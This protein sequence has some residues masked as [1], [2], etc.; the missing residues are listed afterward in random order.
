MVVR[1]RAGGRGPEVLRCG[2]QQLA[3]TYLY[4]GDLGR[5][6]PFLVGRTRRRQDPDVVYKEIRTDGADLR[7]ATPTGN[8]TRHPAPL[9]GAIHTAGLQVRLGAGLRLAGRKY[10]S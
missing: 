7:F 4:V 8:G 10:G 9:L 2:Q 5:T 6:V 3:W 1:L